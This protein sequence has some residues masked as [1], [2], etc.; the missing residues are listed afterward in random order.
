MEN[1]NKEQQP[2]CKLA[3]LA[4][5]HFFLFCAALGVLIVIFL[6]CAAG[7]GNEC[8]VAIVKEQGQPPRKIAISD[9]TIP[10][11][12]L[13]LRE[14]EDTVYQPPRTEYPAPPP[15][16]FYAPATACPVPGLGHHMFRGYDRVREMAN[17]QKAAALP[18]VGCPWMHDAAQS[19]NQ[20]NILAWRIAAL[21][22]KVAELLK[23]E[24]GLKKEIRQLK[25]RGIPPVV[26]APASA[27][28]APAVTGPAVSAPAAV[29]Q[30]AVSVAPGGSVIKA[31]SEKSEAAAAEAA[32]TAIREEYQKLLN[33][34]AKV[35]ALK[36]R[37]AANSALLMQMKE[38][39]MQ[40]GQKSQ[41]APQKSAGGFVA[42]GQPSQGAQPEAEPCPCGT[43]PDQK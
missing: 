33:L 6:V 24:Q 25:K 11:A 22:D 35:E 34:H 26:S 39:A 10:Q 23:S 27:I 40:P 4:R 41:A 9:L 19:H 29:N 13:L 38:A 36:K 43:L 2:C 42:P 5:E 37:D 18:G 21:E 16:A 31:P 7:T 8:T 1:E 14:F 20:V 15:A 3:K 30:G 12:Q 17:H 28:S 32:L